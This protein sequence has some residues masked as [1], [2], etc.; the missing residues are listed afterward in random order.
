M[1][2]HEVTVTSSLTQISIIKY[3][4]T[5][6]IMTKQTKQTMIIIASN[7]TQTCHNSK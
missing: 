3:Q 1:T 6:I 5:I 2:N 4:Q 7:Q